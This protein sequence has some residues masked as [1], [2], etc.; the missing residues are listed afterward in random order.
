MKILLI[1]GILLICFAIY[2]FLTSNAVAV[3]P[4]RNI[5]PV[6]QVPVEAPRRAPVS[7]EVVREVVQHEEPAYYDSLEMPERV[8]GEPDT[9]RHPERLFRPA[10]ENGNT[11]IAVESGSASMITQ[12]QQYRPDFIQNGG[13]MGDIV[14]AS[15]HDDAV[16]SEFN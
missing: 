1:T 10:P 8:A 11:Q 12:M 2:T 3:K 7:H 16:F 14:P 5:E 15:S 6:V 13:A 9:M 4:A